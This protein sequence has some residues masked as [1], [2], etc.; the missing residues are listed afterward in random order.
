MTS[1][2]TLRTTHSPHAPQSEVGLHD[3]VDDMIDIF[4]AGNMKAKTA[5]LS[6]KAKNEQIKN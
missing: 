2:R 3:H 1:L 4:I 5:L 6:I